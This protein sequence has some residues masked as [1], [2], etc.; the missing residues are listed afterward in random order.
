[1]KDCKEGK[2]IQTQGSTYLLGKKF[3]PRKYWTAE[4][5]K[6]AAEVGVGAF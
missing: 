5:V 3:E 6:E 4:V 1:M 2:V